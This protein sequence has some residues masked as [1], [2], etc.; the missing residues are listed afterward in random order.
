MLSLIGSRDCVDSIVIWLWAG[1]RRNVFLA[2]A[3]DFSLQNIQTGSGTQY[4]YVRLSVKGK[5]DHILQLVLR[6]MC[7]GVP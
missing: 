1:Q 3:Q 6:L 7:G 2:K 5:V 4:K